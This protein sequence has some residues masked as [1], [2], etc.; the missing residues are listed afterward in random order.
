MAYC[1]EAKVESYIPNITIDT[2]SKPTSAQVAEMIA[3]IAAE[4]DVVF[5]SMGITV[6]VTEPAELLA[7]CERINAV[8]A[9]GSA[10]KA[11]FFGGRDEDEGLGGWLW[12]TYQDMMSRIRKGEFPFSLGKDADAIEIDS[13]AVSQTDYADWDEPTFRKLSGDKNF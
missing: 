3:G 8:G 12:E 9:A 10:M 6:A 4:M 7:L 1:T 13:Y 5:S 11:M 2:N